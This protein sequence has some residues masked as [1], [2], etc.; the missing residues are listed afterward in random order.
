MKQVISSNILGGRILTFISRIDNKGPGAHGT[1]EDHK[2]YN[3]DKEK[4]I[5]TPGY[6]S[7]WEISTELVKSR[8]TVDLFV[9]A[10]APIDLPFISPIC[11]DTGGD[12]YF[13]KNFTDR[14]DGERMMYDVFRI[15]T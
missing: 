8:I 11:Y 14:Y 2:F 4:E 13:Y 15:L 9:C 12:L 6:N 3:T 5:M 7:Y 10:H 1:R